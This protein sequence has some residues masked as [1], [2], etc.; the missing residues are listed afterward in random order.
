MEVVAPAYPG[1]PQGGVQAAVCAC[2]LTK[3]LEPLLTPGGKARGG[4]GSGLG[5]WTLPRPRLTP[6]GKAGGVQ[7]SGLG[8]WTL[9]RPRLGQGEEG[10]RKGMAVAGGGQE[11]HGCSRWAERGGHV[12]VALVWVRVMTGIKAKAMVRV[13]KAEG[14]CEDQGHTWP[15]ARPTHPP[16]PPVNPPTRPSWR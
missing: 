2:Q 1:A 13:T 4:Q 3:H 6:G 15:P 10:M 11:G 9:P 8:R 14:E 7:G 5:R 12:H 16:G